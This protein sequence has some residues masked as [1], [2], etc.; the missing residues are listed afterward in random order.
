MAAVLFVVLMDI[1]G[2]GIISPLFPF[3][4]MRTGA[5]PGAIMF[6][7]ALYSAALFISAPLLGRLSDKYGR[8]TVMATSLLGSIAG[9]VLLMCATN[10]WMIALSRL[11]GGAMA[12]N[13]SA[14]QAYIA[15]H[16]DES[17][18]PRMMGMFGAAMGLGFI[19]GPVLGSLLG[20]ESFAA[21]NFFAP[22]FAAI[23]L[24][25]VGLL[26]VIVFVKEKPLL[27]TEPQRSKSSRLSLG[28]ALREAHIEGPQ[29]GLLIKAAICIVLYQTASGLYE[30]I[31][32]I[33]AKDHSIASGPKGLLPI[34]LAGGFGYVFIQAVIGKI[35]N[36]N[37]ERRV[38]II[39]SLVYMTA[40]LLMPLSGR[41]SSTIAVILL[42][43]VTACAAGLVFSTSQILIS[44]CV[45]TTARGFVLGSINSLGMLGK[46]VA[47]AV[48]GF[49]YSHI[50]S[51][52]P[53]F[54][55]A[56]LALA[57]MTNALLMK[58]G[59]TSNEPSQSAENMI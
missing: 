51:H 30:T 49:I 22:A 42:T 14:A 15:D 6:C 50:G 12:G 27:H 53:Y 8:K 13:F 43:G 40:H 9:Y 3:Y 36:E 38:L 24:S 41:Y 20:G 26:S 23:L 48:S 11:I 28:A 56:V 29:A 10:I 37:N 54:F 17:S 58:R 7:M 1:V 32:P 39:G 33:W 31:F 21:A 57:L 52:A 2:I 59:A 4:A 19:L 47:I 34:F 45:G 55:S 16:T 18:R 35:V 44:C 5:T 46:T 25:A